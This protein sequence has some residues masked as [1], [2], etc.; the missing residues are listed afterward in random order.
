M[1][2]KIYN[3]SWGEAGDVVSYSIAFSNS[4]VPGPIGPVGP[5]GPV[6]PPGTTDFN[7][8]QNVPSAFPPDSHTHPISE[9]TNLQSELDS[10]AE[11]EHTHR[12]SEITDFAERVAEVSPP[13]DWDTLEGKPPTFPPDSHTH[14]ISEVTNLQSE[15]DGKAGTGHT[16][17]DATQTTAGFL[18]PTD[19]TKLDGVA[20]GAEV[21]VNADWNAT[22]GDAAILN[23]P[24]TFP[25]STHAASHTNGTDDIQNATASQKGLATAAQIAKLDGIAANANNYAHPNHSGDVTSVGDGATTIANDAVTNAKLANV[26][27][28]TLKGRISTGTGDPE[29]LTASDV[30]T[31]INVADGA[32]VN[33]QANWTE[34]DTG[35][36]AFI[37]NKPTLGTAA[38]ANTTDFATAAQGILADTAIQPADLA[39]YVTSKDSYIIVQAGDDLAAKY[40]QAKTLT[41]NGQ[42]LSATNRASLI[43]FPA[44]YSLAAELSINAEFVDIIGLGAQTLE[45]GSI[46]AV[47]IT[48]NTFNVTAND[49]RV[50]GISVGDQRFNITGTK[51]LQQFDHCTGGEYSFGETAAAGTFKNCVGGNTSFGDAGLASGTFINCTGGNT[52]F[53]TFGTASGIFINCEASFSFGAVGSASGTFVNCEGL[54]ASFGGDS[55]TA[56]GTFVNCIGGQYAFGGFALVGGSTGTASGTFINCTGGIESFGGAGGIASGVFKD[57]TGGEGSFG[58][59]GS[60]VSGRFTNCTGGVYSFGYQGTASG[61]FINCNGS[62]YS[63]GGDGTASGSFFDCS[64]INRSFGGFGLAS[65]TF[66][67]CSAEAESF[68]GDAGTA[69]GTF[70]DCVAGADSFGALIA[71]GKFYQCRLLIGTFNTVTGGGLMRNCIDGNNNIVDQ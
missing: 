67:R 63:F 39:P 64:A 9:V 29:D 60:I 68:G 23:K 48:D 24:A 6:G 69:T 52:S 22:T 25:P 21:N 34:S 66:V 61:I 32:E 59:Y 2:A 36:D 1:Q 51:P 33:V 56:S 31:I 4:G 50:Q 5:V 44:N 14:S 47:T 65:G 8:L 30:R 45:R 57:C 17:A 13:A 19:K 10:K 54:D 15:L 28:S 20:T 40:T 43:V 53:A 46:P 11:S 26:A 37:L 35:S 62:A 3:L 38:A 7:E 12:A 70:T 55:G 71:S 42:A 41:P 49:V 18:S 16:H 27:T 58:S